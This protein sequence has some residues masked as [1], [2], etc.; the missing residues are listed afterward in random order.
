MSKNTNNQW[1][2]S[3]SLAKLRDYQEPAFQAADGKPRVIVNMPTGWGKSF[4]L[5]ALAASDLRNETRRIVICVPQRVIAKGFEREL[6]IELPNGTIVTWPAPRNLCGESPAKVDALTEF[7]LAPALG[8]ANMRIVL[9]THVTLSKALQRVDDQQLAG[10][11]ESLTVVVDEAHHILASEHGQNTLGGQVIRLL[12]SSTTT[13]KLWLATAFFFRGDHL[14]IFSESHMSEFSRIH[15]PFDEYWGILK[16]IKSYSYDFVSYKGTVF[17][18]LEHILS[19]E[20]ESP[21]IIYCPPEGHQML[22][23]KGK[24]RFVARVS[25]IVDRCL[26]AAPWTSFVSG[27]SQQSV[28]IDLVETEGRHEKLRFIAEHGDRVAAILT[29]GM[30]REGADWIQASRIVDLVPTNSDQDRLQRFGRLV[31]DCD[32]KTHISYVSFFPHVVEQGEESRRRQLTK[33]YA[34]FHAS[35]VLENAI[36]PITVTVPTSRTNLP[37]GKEDNNSRTRHN[38]LGDLPEPQQE[39][40]IRSSYEKLIALHVQKADQDTVA[41]PEEVHRTIVSALKENGVEDELEAFAK[42]I[43]VMMRRKADVS[44]K[45]DDL[46]DAGFDKVYSSDIFEPIIAYSGAMGGPKTLAEIRRVVEN[47]FEQ[48]WDEMFQRIKDLPKPPD[49]QSSAYWWCTHNRVLRKTGELSESRATRLESIHW[50]VW[51]VAVAERWE[52]VF[53]TLQRADRCPK[54]GSREYAWVRQQRRMFEEGKLDDEQVRRLETIPWWKWQSQKGNWEMR[55]QDVAGLTTRP[56]R[57]TKLYEWVRTQ[58]KAFKSGVLAPD[59]IRKLESISWWLW[60]ERRSDRAEGIKSLE[61]CIRE[62]VAL[63]HTKAQVAEKW[64]EAMGIGADQVHK[65]LRKLSPSSREQW[66]A[67]AG[68]RRKLNAH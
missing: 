56:A 47:V 24:Q 12:D 19:A 5:C 33:L 9:T 15:V 3:M 16:H 60:E 26:D 44:L 1:R 65:Y 13:L 25:E 45:T 52:S 39:A 63:R 48:Q 68:E 10:V 35:L 59:R 42:Q 38:L 46:V 18:E 32:G 50:W 21:T 20:T 51:S 55:F 8:M 17:D 30:F 31:R 23:G 57:Q 14:P 27:L 66:T 2:D 29:V 64:A 7:L 54:S 36:H 4:L 41:S 49:T 22:L 58:R 53:T 28:T 11:A 67:L 37:R 61:L 40:I 43:L 62:G 34:H 6:Q